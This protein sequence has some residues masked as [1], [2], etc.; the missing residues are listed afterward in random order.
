MRAPIMALF[1]PDAL[2]ELIH[3]TGL[4]AEVTHA[5]PLGIEGAVLIAL[6]TALLLK[7][8]ENPLIVLPQSQTPEFQKRLQLARTWLEAKEPVSAK[9][10]AKHLGNGI[11]APTSCVTAIYCAVRFLDDEFVSMLSFIKRMGGDVDTIGAIAGSLWGAYNGAT[12]LPTTKIEQRELIIKTARDLFRS[13]QA[14]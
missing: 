11:T 13:A 6:T 1:R 10:V 7:K 4:S 14:C 2:T 12:Q 9:Q 8:P 5:H 3:N